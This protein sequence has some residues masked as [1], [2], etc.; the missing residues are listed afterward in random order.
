MYSYHLRVHAPVSFTEFL[1]PLQY[2]P[3]NMVTDIFSLSLIIYHCSSL[4]QLQIQLTDYYF[5]TQMFLWAGNNDV[6]K[7]LNYCTNERFV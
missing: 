4:E 1:C 6:I 5:A 3:V 7:S 2:L